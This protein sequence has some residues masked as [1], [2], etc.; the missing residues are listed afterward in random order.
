MSQ[1]QALVL[2]RSGHM[3]QAVMMWQRAVALAQQIEH[4][5]KAALYETAAAACEA[6]FGNGAAAKRRA[7]AALKIRKGRDVEYAA[8]YA[9]ALAGDPSG[10]QALADDLGK[11]FPE[12]TA[13]Q[14]EY[15]P[16]LGALLALARH[17]PLKAIE[18]LQPA[19][20][21]DFAMPG[22]AFA[23]NFGGLYPAYV[24]G[25]AYL[26]AR[27]GVEAAAEFQKILDHRG[28]VGADPVGALAHL[29]LG[30][31]FAL[32]GDKTKAKTAYQDFLTLWKD[33]DPDILILKQARAEYAKLQE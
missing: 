32:S 12:D 11:R 18:L 13:V 9:L 30:R 20:A 21:Y 25:Q 17:E 24:R 14:F 23:A 26:A 29:Q 19:L 33:A 4:R 3:K 31:A 1:Q 22:T 15:I 8:A 5:E 16:T 7:L 28:V 10:A 6:H 2:A 27:Q